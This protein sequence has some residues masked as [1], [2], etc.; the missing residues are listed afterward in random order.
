MEPPPQPESLYFPPD[1]LSILLKSLL[2][3]QRGRLLLSCNRFYTSFAHD[4]Q[5]WSE[6]FF[7]IGLSLT[8]RDSFA[9]G[10]RREA[11]LVRKDISLAFSSIQKLASQSLRSMRFDFVAG[12]P[13]W[14]KHDSGVSYQTAD[15]FV[16]ETTVSVKTEEIISHSSYSDCKVVEC[17]A[18]DV[19]NF[20]HDGSLPLPFVSEF[21][22]EATFAIPLGAGVLCRNDARIV[23]PIF[24]LHS[25]GQPADTSLGEP[26]AH[27]FR[28]M[29]TR[30]QS[31][32]G[33][34]ASAP[35]Q[36]PVP[37]HLPAFQKS[38]MDPPAL[39]VKLFGLESRFAGLSVRSD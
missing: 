7:E 8:K 20:G 10:D 31:A 28:K 38:P 29:A 17:A 1:V 21:G 34:T 4:F 22:A 18:V 33:P 26:A 14:L 3:V 19:L 15:L 13:G 24:R 35:S 36:V 37:Q 27:A 2:A 25:S 30:A 6:I 9:R 23:N 12:V 32:P 11:S 5:L 16:G 39:F